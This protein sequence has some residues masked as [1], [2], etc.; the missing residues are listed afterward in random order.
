MAQPPGGNE[1]GRAPSPSSSP[2]SS[3]STSVCPRS[4]PVSPVIRIASIEKEHR[5]AT[6]H[7]LLQ[8]GW[9][10]WP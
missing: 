10:E 1:A 8:A 3:S 7:M 9:K 2:S 6:T 4:S 5:K